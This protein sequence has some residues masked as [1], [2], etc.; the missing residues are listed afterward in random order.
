MPSFDIVSKLNMQE[1]D[2]AVNQAKKEIEARFDFKGSKTELNLDQKENLIKIETS[3]DVRLKATIDVL[4]TKLVKRGISLLGLVYNKA[5]GAGGQRLRQNI[6]LV[7]GIEKEKAKEVVA[8]IKKLNLKVQAQIM[9][10]QL[11]VTGKNKDDLQTAI[12]TLRG[13]QSLGIPLQFIN[14]RD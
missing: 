5:E 12:Q 11:R 7:M 1:V 8:L 13:D 4:N 3:D 14:F 2:N 10:D 6:G 9:D